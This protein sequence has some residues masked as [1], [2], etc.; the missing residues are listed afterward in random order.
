MDK[1]EGALLDAAVEDVFAKREVYHDRLKSVST[2]RKANKAECLAEDKKR[3][4]LIEKAVS[5]VRERLESSKDDEGLAI[6]DVD[7]ER[8]CSDLGIRLND[9][10]KNVMK[11]SDMASTIAAAKN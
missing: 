9:N 11:L 10:V 4:D 8:T 6:P 7:E 1:L 2:K 5:S 3:V